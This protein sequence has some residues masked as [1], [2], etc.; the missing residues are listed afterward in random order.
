[1]Y[2]E[3]QELSRRYVRHG[4]PLSVTD[5][6]T[7]RHVRGGSSSAE[8]HL[9]RIPTGA[10]AMSSIEFV[11]I[12]HGPRAGRC[13]WTL[14]HGLRRCATMIVKLT[15]RGPLS[16]RSARK[17]EELRST[18]SAAAKLL[19]GQTP[20]YPLVKTLARGRHQ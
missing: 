16:A 10:S 5:G 17:E 4:L 6:L 3:D 9:R 7:G 20:H 14:Y 19:E 15:A 12:T 18:Q 13:A 1:M 8:G 11:A 2:Y